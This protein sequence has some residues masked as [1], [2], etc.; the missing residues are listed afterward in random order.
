MRKMAATLRRM[1]VHMEGN[2]RDSRVCGLVP[3]G[4]DVTATRLFPAW[5]SDSSV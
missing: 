2:S 5:I 1:Y 3:T 4:T